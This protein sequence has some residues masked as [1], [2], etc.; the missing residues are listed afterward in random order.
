MDEWDYSKLKCWCIYSIGGKN[1]MKKWLLE[2]E[3][4]FY[5]FI[6]GLY[7]NCKELENVNRSKSKLMIIDF[8]YR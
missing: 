8:I 7:L 2:W 3:G 6:R 1:W 5:K 4:N